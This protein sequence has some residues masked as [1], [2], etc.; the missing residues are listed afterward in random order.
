MLQTC[1]EHSGE[2]TTMLKYDSLLSLSVHQLFY[3]KE[4]VVLVSA[5]GVGLMDPILQP[6]TPG[7][8]ARSAV[9]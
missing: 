1:I 7:L 9:C 6:K 4:M 8:I 2:V 5:C 3:L